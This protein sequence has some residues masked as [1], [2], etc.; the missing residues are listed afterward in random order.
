MGMCRLRTPHSNLPN[1]IAQY[2]GVAQA[3]QLSNDLV[4][5]IFG[6]LDAHVRV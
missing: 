1:R 4:T 2:C 5:E 3:Y 6:P